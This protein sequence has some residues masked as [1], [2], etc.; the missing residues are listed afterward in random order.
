MQATIWLRSFLPLGLHVNEPMAQQ[1]CP[2]IRA[3]TSDSGKNL[4]LP[5]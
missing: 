3:L 4:H 2:R 1:P 5:F